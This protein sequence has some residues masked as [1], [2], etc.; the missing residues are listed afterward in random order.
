MRSRL[1]TLALLLVAPFASAE[2]LDLTNAK[3]AEAATVLIARFFESIGLDVFGKGNTHF[4]LK[5]AGYKMFIATY[6]DVDE[7]CRLNAHISFV[8]RKE[9]VGNAKLLSL[10]NE[11]NESY[12]YAVMSV[13]K[14]GDLNFR[15]TLLFDKKL[16]AKVVHRW[17]RYIER[18]TD[19]ALD[20]YKDQLKSFQA[21]ER[22]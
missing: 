11:I 19:G 22:R 21:T 15:F 13:D 17:L 20:E 9:N 10:V 16:D 7:G 3:N 14:D 18:Q 5:A 6:F 8:G 2:P 12:N 1:L 4:G